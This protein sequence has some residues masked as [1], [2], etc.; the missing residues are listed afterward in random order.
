MSHGKNKPGEPGADTL[1]KT[2]VQTKKKSQSRKS[3]HKAAKAAK[4]VKPQNS[5]VEPQ[6]FNEEPQNTDKEPQNIDTDQDQDDASALVI[7]SEPK[8]GHYDATVIENEDGIDNE[9]KN[10]EDWDGDDMDDVDASIGDDGI[11]I[12][13]DENVDNIDNIDIGIDVA[14]D[15]CSYGVA[16]RSKGPKK[17]GAMIDKE[18]DDDDEGADRNVDENELNPDIYVKPEERRAVDH[19]TLYEKVRLLGDRTA[20]LAQGAKPM[21][22]GVENMSP[23][24]IAQ[25]ELESK[26]I[27]IKIVRPLPNGKKEIWALKELKLKKKY[28]IYGF[29]GGDLD[30]DAV[31]KIRSEYQKGGSITGYYHLTDQYK[32]N[33]NH[34]T[35]EHTNKIEPTSKP[36]SRAKSKS[37][38]NKT[39]KIVKVSNGAKNKQVV[40][41]K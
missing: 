33:K 7:G 10:N 20:Q 1:S 16:R 4:V 11:D 12:D 15:E 25:L 29:T 13:N 19:L 9:D 14:D 5:D 32:T 3:N 39:V 22:K 30:R 31:E 18:D 37:E 17:L 35:G 6:N 2:N 41:E 24:V 26:M 28:I 23:R 27:P 8:Y 38:P 34:T 36:K 21:I 40:R